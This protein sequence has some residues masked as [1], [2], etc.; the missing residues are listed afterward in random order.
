MAMP[1]Q[2]GNRPK[3]QPSGNRGKEN[4]HVVLCQRGKLNR[5]GAGEECRQPDVAL[6]SDDGLRRCRAVIT[7]HAQHGWVIWPL[8]GGPAAAS[9]VPIMWDSR[10]YGTDQK[11]AGQRTGPLASQDQPRTRRFRSPDFRRR[12]TPDGLFK[13]GGHSGSQLKSCRSEWCSP[14]TTSRVGH[15]A[16][17]TATDFITWRD[18]C[19]VG[20]RIGT[21]PLAPWVRQRISVGLAQPQWYRPRSRAV[22]AAGSALA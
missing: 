18:N 2:L 19:T 14:I 17:V 1:I 7:T 20:P 11:D 5:N 12:R 10:H 6:N 15:V 16:G 22:G 8:S 3:G 9:V 4:T 21:T 13:P